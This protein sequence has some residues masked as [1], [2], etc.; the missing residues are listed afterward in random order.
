MLVEIGPHS[1]P[2][3]HFFDQIYLDENQIHVLFHMLQTANSQYYFLQL[4]KY[5]PDRYV[6]LL[7]IIT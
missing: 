4:F 1:D 5:L 7:A 6:I 3:N 2:L